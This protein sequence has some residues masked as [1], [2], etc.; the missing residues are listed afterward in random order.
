MKVETFKGGYDRNFSYLI[1]DEISKMGYVIDPLKDTEQ[2]Y[3]KS[4]E[5]KVYI[6]GVLNTHG[7]FDHTEGNASFKDKGIPL[8]DNQI[9]EIAL[10]R[11]K[12]KVIKTPGHTSDS[13]SFFTDGKLFSG[14]TLFV[15]KIGGTEN[16]GAA[17]IQFA[18]LQ[19][20]TDLPDDT[21]V[22]PG[23]DLGVTP[24]STIG[25]EKRTNPFLL[26]DNI[27][28]F[29]WLKNNWAKFKKENNIQ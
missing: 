27:E 21:I 24:T 1:Y 29:L 7:H 8:V 2:Y 28:D 9:E 5:L 22:Y 12:I 19:K 14:D 18:S 10:G 11:E 13:V 15:G 25:N 20:L 17:G 3:E 6:T 26:R 23:H 4:K 16:E